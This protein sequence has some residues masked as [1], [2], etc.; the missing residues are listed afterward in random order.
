MSWGKT[1][2]S[3]KQVTIALCIQVV[4]T[5]VLYFFVQIQISS[6]CDCPTNENLGSHA[7]SYAVDSFQYDCHY[8]IHLMIENS[9]INIQEEAELTLIILAEAVLQGDS[10]LLVYSVPGFGTLGP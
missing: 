10:S 8:K 6:T 9:E 7:I 4:F 1:T 2:Y 5:S 3:F